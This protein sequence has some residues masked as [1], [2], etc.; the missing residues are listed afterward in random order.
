MDVLFS[1]V[2]WLGPLCLIGLLIFELDRTVYGKKKA[3]L[4][5]P[6]KILVVLAV[7]LGGFFCVLLAFVAMMAWTGDWL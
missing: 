3:P 7:F 2:A 1:T 4:S 6:A 5:E